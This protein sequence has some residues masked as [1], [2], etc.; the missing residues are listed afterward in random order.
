MGGYFSGIS[1]SRLK[2]L[3]FFFPTL[4]ALG[5]LV[6]SCIGAILLDTG[7]DLN[8]VWKVMLL[9]LNPAMRF[10]NL[11]LSPIRELLELCQYHGWD[12]KFIPSKRNRSFMVEAI[13]DGKSFASV[14]YRSIKGAKRMAAQQA[15]QKLKVIF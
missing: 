2:T 11:Q 5:D 1:F 6:E 10:S 8:H 12:S 9:F 3:L 4:Q 7:F 14:T 13:V 15:T